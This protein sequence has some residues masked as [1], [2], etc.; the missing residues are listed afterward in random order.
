MKCPHLIVRLAFYENL[1]IDSR[2]LPDRLSKRQSLS[3]EIVNSPIQ[4]YIHFDD[5]TQPTYKKVS[6]VHINGCPY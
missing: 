4:D 3:I 1:F 5:H 2:W 6:V